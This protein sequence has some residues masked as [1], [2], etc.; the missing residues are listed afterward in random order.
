MTPYERNTVAVN[1]GA[2][3]AVVMAV[4]LM[5]IVWLTS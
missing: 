2:V 5:L 1:F 4:G 3:W